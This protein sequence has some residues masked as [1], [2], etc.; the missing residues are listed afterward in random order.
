MGKTAKVVSVSEGKFVVPNLWLSRFDVG[1]CGKIK[2]AESELSILAK[3]SVNKDNHI[4][5]DVTLETANGQVTQ[6]KVRNKLGENFMIIGLPNALFGQ[7]SPR[8]ETVIFMVPRLIRTLKTT[9]TI[10]NKI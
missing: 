6:F 4:N 3:A 5:T 1:K 9:E 10:K 2:C 8:S 7:T